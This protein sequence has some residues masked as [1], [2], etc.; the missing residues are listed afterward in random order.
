MADVQ[1]AKGFTQLA[2][3]LLGALAQF[4]F[5]E[6]QYSLLLLV[7]RL[8]YG[9][10]KKTASF[11]S[12]LEISKLTGVDRQNVKPNLWFLQAAHVLFVDWDNMVLGCNKNYDHWHIEKK[13]LI[14]PGLLE[15][16]IKRNL[17]CNA[18]ITNVITELHESL[19]NDMD[20]IVQLQKCNYRITSDRNHVITELHR[21]DLDPHDNKP[22][23]PPKESKNKE[24]K[25]TQTHARTRSK[26]LATLSKEEIIQFGFWLNSVY[27][28]CNPTAEDHLA[29][30]TRIVKENNRQ[31]I[32]DAVEELKQAKVGLA[33]RLDWLDSYL[34]GKDNGKE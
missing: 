33:D 16:V 29:I 34:E 8:S 30:L 31:T 5:N 26:E 13:Y 2:N 18:T 23:L 32:L 20:V 21:P 3:E 17:A 15:N 19:E 7:I 24:S 1:L 27:E 6:S 22:E 28:I 10:K 9:C 25:E 4:K 14:E 11:R 12:W